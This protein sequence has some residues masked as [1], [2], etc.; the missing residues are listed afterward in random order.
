MLHLETKASS[1]RRSH[2]LLMEDAAQKTEAPCILC[3]SLSGWILSETRSKR[4]LSNRKNFCLIFSKTKIYAPLK[5]RSFYL[6]ERRQNSITIPSDIQKQFDKNSLDTVQERRL[7]TPLD[8][9]MPRAQTELKPGKSPTPD[10]FIDGR[11]TGIK[12]A[13]KQ[14]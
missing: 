4:I 10:A 7:Q 12:T 1:K 8:D 11:L 9:T 13:V 5:N 14:L 6:R 2:F 3:S